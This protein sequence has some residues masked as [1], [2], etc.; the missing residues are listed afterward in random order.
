[1]KCDRNLPAFRKNVLSHNPN[2]IRGSKQNKS[3]SSTMKMEIVHSSET[4]IDF[5]QT[6]RRHISEDGTIELIVDE[7]HLYEFLK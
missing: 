2:K 5:Y 4:S 3:C 7:I 6:T 1:V